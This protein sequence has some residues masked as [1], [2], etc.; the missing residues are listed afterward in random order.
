MIIFLIVIFVLSFLS[1]STI[2]S[3][4]LYND[5]GF[6]L[7]YAKFYDRKFKLFNFSDPQYDS[8]NFSFGG[9]DHIF[10]IFAKLFG[11]KSD[12]FFKIIQVIW[13]S[14]IF[15][16]M[17]YYILLITQNYFSAIVAFFFAI[18]VGLH[19]KHNFHILLG[20]TYYLLQFFI[21]NILLIYYTQTSNE[22]FIFLCGI[23]AAWMMLSKIVALPIVGYYLIIIF[24]LGG[25]KNS[26]IYAAGVILLFSIANI[27]II[28]KSSWYG[29][30]YYNMSYWGPLIE[31]FKIVFKSHEELE[32]NSYV[33]RMQKSSNPDIKNLK[34]TNFFLLFEHFGSIL[35]LGGL[36]LIYGIIELDWIILMHLG[37]FLIFL[38]ILKIQNFYFITKLNAMLFPLIISVTLMLD[39]VMLNSNSIK[40]NIFIVAILVLTHYKLII[41]ASFQFAK[42]NRSRILGFNYFGLILSLSKAIGQFINERT[43]NKNERMIVWGN[44]PNIYFY[45]DLP[46][47]LTSSLFMYPARIPLLDNTK[48][49]LFSYCKFQVPKWYVG[50]NYFINDNWTVKD[51]SENTGIPY[52][53]I[54]TF[55]IRNSSNVIRHVCGKNYEL[56]VF[57]RDDK[58][59]KEILIRKIITENQT[60][61]EECF[62]FYKSRF[63]FW[64]KYYCPK[65][66]VKFP[67]YEKLKNQDLKDYYQEKLK[68]L[69]PKDKILF[70]ISETIGSS[71]DEKIKFV[72]KSTVISKNTILKNVILACLFKLSGNFEQAKDVLVETLKIDDSIYFAHLDYGEIVFNLGD[73]ETAFASFVKAIEINELSEEGFNNIG[74]VYININNFK[75]A[76]K[77]FKRAI[78]LNPDF[79]E[80]KENLTFLMEKQMNIKK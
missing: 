15:T 8:N 51:F 16:S 33:S 49:T 7:F 80:A 14:L 67:V 13:L 24:V 20:E 34:K 68:R 18:I 40:I 37:N 31:K 35:L 76:E 9:L 70:E 2:I 43:T 3:K 78:Q 54:K 47:V 45:S 72:S 38:L 29:M 73:L 66:G 11:G 10:Y 39:K 23:L 59:Y 74:V 4:P 36:A 21:I 62:Q 65:M 17:S 52:K 48:R 5:D 27:Y 28:F 19:P 50:A 22:Y 75:E 25:I 57:E 30:V 26:V 61:K 63:E 44:L 58:L 1:F 71:L 69:Y 56:P 60:E 6:F 42:G 41:E 55:S 79:K 46:P 32:E 12:R 64:N 53:H 77:Y